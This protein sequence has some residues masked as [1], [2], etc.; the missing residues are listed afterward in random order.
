MIQ[1]EEF[2]AAFKNCMTSQK[3]LDTPMQL[4]LNLKNVCLTQVSLSF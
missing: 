3:P 4:I 2:S 1:K